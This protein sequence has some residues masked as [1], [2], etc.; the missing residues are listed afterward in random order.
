MML[1]MKTQNII[2]GWWKYHLSKSWIVNLQQANN[3]VELF[4]YGGRTYNSFI[5]FEWTFI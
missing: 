3:E 2:V 1:S 5:F 4:L